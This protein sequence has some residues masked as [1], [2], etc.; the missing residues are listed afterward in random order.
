MP[1]RDLV[2]WNSMLS[3]YSQGGSHEEC[4]DLYR[5]M[6]GLE[7]VRPDGV[8]AVSVLHACAQSTDL[9]FGMEVH[10]YVMDNGIKM[11]LSVCNSIIAL[12]A[13]CGSLDYAREL[14]EEMTEKMK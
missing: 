14:F 3:G 10:Q 2:S 5:M 9:V 4:K 6:L 11:D 1:D 8:T 7:D 12:Y 13:K